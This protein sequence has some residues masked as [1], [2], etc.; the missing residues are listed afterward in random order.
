VLIS[1]TSVGKALTNASAFAAKVD[2]SPLSGAGGKVVIVVI[3]YSFFYF[4][5]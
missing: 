3:L 1:V 5:N 2:G 4:Y